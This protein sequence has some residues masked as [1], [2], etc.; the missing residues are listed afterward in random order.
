MNLVN[1]TKSLL[2]YDP[3]EEHQGGRMHR[4][5]KHMGRGRDGMDLFY[6]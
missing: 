4:K 5:K 2:N 6:A 3:D 1:A